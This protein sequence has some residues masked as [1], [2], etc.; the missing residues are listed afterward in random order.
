MSLLKLTQIT[1]KITTLPLK[2]IATTL[3]SDVSTL[4]L[5]DTNPHKKHLYF[6]HGQLTNFV[7]NVHFR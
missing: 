3:S 4:T 2:W 6:Y 7:D 5:V 1:Q